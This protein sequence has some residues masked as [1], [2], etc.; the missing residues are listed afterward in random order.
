MKIKKQI[1]TFVCLSDIRSI[2][3][4]VGN[5]ID[6]LMNGDLSWSFGDNNRTLIS[7]SSF[8]SELK[9]SLETDGTFS[10]RDSDENEQ[11]VGVIFIEDIVEKIKKSISKGVMYVDLEN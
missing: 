11:T 7:G 4:N 2:D 9:S 10:S 1:A 6:I 8:L 3:E 5:A